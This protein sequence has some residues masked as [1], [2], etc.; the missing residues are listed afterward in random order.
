MSTM[1]D[2]TMYI[3]LASTVVISGSF[4]VLAWR[5]LRTSLIN[6]QKLT[7]AMQNLGQI[8]EQATSDHTSIATIAALTDRIE[9][10]EQRSRTALAQ[11]T[12]AVAQ[13]D[14]VEDRLKSHVGRY[15][16]EGRVQRAEDE[17]NAEGQ[18]LSDFMAAAQAMPVVSDEVEPTNKRRR[19]RRRRGA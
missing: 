5:M 16:R 13:I 9:A 3:I 7:D 1:L 11:T 8:V 14:R 2:V 19:R 17:E 15:L 4:G 12:D 6:A 18:E 10:C